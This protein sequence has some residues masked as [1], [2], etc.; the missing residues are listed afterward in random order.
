MLKTTKPKILV[1]AIS[2]HLWGTGIPLQDNS[3]LDKDKWLSTGWL[4][5]MLLTIHDEI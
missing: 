4:S 2:V 1:E 5:R 3:A